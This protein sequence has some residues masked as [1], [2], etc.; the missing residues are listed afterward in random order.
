M[1]QYFTWHTTN[2]VSMEYKELAVR[3]A[4]NS[5]CPAR[6]DEEVFLS[7]NCRCLFD[8][9]GEDQFFVALHKLHSARCWRIEH[10]NLLS[11]NC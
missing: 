8:V 5:V 6:D 4:T 11:L 3:P 10:F 2:I 9:I 1:E 7:L